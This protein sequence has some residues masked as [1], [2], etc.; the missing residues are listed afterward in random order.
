[1]TDFWLCLILVLMLVLM[2]SIVMV[3]NMGLKER[4]KKLEALL[5]RSSVPTPVT[6]ETPAETIL[7]TGAR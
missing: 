1:M 2:L 6:N 7:K 4:L 5:H 3:Q